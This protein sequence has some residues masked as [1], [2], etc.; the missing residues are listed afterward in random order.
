MTITFEDEGAAAHAEPPAALAL[1]ER[2]G[3]TWTGELEG[4]AGPLRSWLAAQPIEDFVVGPPEL[5][6]LFRAF[7]RDEEGTPC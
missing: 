1:L 2:R 7:Y 5:E 6:T 4:S 3:R